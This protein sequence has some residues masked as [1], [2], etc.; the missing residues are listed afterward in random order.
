MIRLEKNPTETFVCL[1]SGHTFLKT[2]TQNKVWDRKQNSETSSTS[3]RTRIP[4]RART[5]TLQRTHIILCSGF[6]VL[7]S[8]FML[9][10]RGHPRTLHSAFGGKLDSLSKFCV[11]YRLISLPKPSYG[12]LILLQEGGCPLKL[13]LCVLELTFTLYFIEIF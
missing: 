2:N 3:A 9:G 4:S 6:A 5:R 12:N 10:A 1:S 11:S 13:C 8:A 7:D